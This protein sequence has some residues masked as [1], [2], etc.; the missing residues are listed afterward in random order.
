MN[1][2]ELFV[3]FSVAAF[4]RHNGQIGFSG[5]LFA[6]MFHIEG[7]SFSNFGLHYRQSG[8][9]NFGQITCYIKYFG[10]IIIFGL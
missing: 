5:L 6:P 7:Y 4:R 3:L 2:V 10:C 8:F 9:L 1:S